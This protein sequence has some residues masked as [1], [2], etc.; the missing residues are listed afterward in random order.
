MFLGTLK[1]F[2]HG[3]FLHVLVSSIGVETVSNHICAWFEN[4]PKCLNSFLSLTQ[5]DYVFC[6][7]NV[8]EM[9][10]AQEQS[11]GTGFSSNACIP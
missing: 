8:S 2:Q 3:N 10:L 4:V 7:P 6:D 11:F 9:N 5:A 1:I